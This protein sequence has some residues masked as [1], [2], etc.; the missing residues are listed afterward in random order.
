MN[1]DLKGDS[2]RDGERETEI[3]GE[4]EKEM[5][6]ESESERRTGRGGRR[7]QR[8]GTEKHSDR[9][10]KGRCRLICSHLIYLFPSISLKR[11]TFKF[12][13]LGT[14]AFTIDSRSPL[15]PT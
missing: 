13:A 7:M 12:E 14:A 4:R 6:K 10:T 2:D 5:D 3:K 1:Y 9:G 11:S 15:S 8:E